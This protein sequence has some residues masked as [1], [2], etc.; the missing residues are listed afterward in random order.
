M[1]KKLRS[2]KLLI[3]RNMPPSF[4]TIPGQPFDPKKSEVIK[5]L[6][7]RPAI[8]NFLWDQIKQSD[9]VVYDDKTGKW[10]G[11]DYETDN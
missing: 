7:E 5:W 4:H 1:K 3:A 10:Q 11:V 2:K 6:I 9:D 8:L